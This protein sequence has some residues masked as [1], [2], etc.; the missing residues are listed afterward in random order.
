[1]T[2][3]Q[4]RIARARLLRRGGKT[5]AEIRAVIG[6]VSDDRLQTWLVGIPRPPQTRRSHPLHEE[7]RKARALRAGGATYGEIAAVLHVSKSSLSLWLRDL[8]VPER[9]RRRRAEHLRNMT[10]MGRGGATGAAARARMQVRQQCARQSIDGVAARELFFLGLGLYWAEGAKDKPWRRQGS[11][12]MSNTDPNL[13]RVYLCWLDLLGIGEEERVYT[14]QIHESVDAWTQ[15]QW[16]QRT[17]GVPAANF[18]RPVLK[19]HA[20]TTRRYNTGADY[21]GCL[22]VDVRRATALYDAIAGW[23]AGLAACFEPQRDSAPRVLLGSN[24]P[25]SSKGRT[26]SFGVAYGGSNPSPGAGEFRGSSPWLPPRWW[27]TVAPVGS[28][29]PDAAD[30]AEHL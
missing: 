16:W 20:P 27:E 29:V 17:L 19:R 24:L 11:V 7:R 22:M 15:E 23:W 10:S 8:P 30:P 9:V 1:M 18:R 25:G 4:R 2:D 14:L 13:L 28:A 5:Y 3:N 12:R 6:P 21:H 26:A